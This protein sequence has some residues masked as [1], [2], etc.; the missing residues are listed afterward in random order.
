MREKK[1]YSEIRLHEIANIS[2]GLVINRIN[3][4]KSINNVNKYYSISQK[5]VHENFIDEE[6]FEAIF[7]D[8]A[9]ENKYLAKYNDIIM[10]LSPPY[11]VAMIDF[12]RNDVI[13]PSNFAIIRIKKEFIP[14]FLAYILNGDRLKRQLNRLVE[15]TNVPVIKISNLNNVKI[16]KWNEDKQIKYSRL[17][18]LLDNRRKLLNRKKELEET[19]KKDILSKL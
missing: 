13:I 6:R 7:T 4:Y 19:L 14:R 12:K 11:N 16:N 3:N 10:K 8:K 17:F 2:S 9:I 5:S 1:I 18:Y 15:G